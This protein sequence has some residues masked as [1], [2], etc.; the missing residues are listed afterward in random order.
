MLLIK[1]SRWI[2]QPSGHFSGPDKQNTSIESG[3]AKH[4]QYSIWLLF[5]Q[6]YIFHPACDLGAKPR[7]VLKNVLWNC[8]EMP[9]TFKHTKAYAFSPS[10]AMEPAG[11]KRLSIHPR[12]LGCRMGKQSRKTHWRTENNHKGQV[13][14]DSIWFEQ[15]K[16]NCGFGTDCL[17]AE[18]KSQFSSAFV[19][20]SFISAPPSLFSVASRCELRVPWHSI[21]TRNKPYWWILFL[22][23]TRVE[24][25]LWTSGSRQR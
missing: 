23:L 3:L 24:K 25:S 2:E 19:V 11:E 9:G 17:A 21:H 7:E 20:M 14:T 6:T 15:I 12:F 5:Y 10:L 16:W 22:L 4:N 1:Y 8:P 18:H 13:W